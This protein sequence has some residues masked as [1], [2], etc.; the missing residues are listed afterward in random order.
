MPKNQNHLYNALNQW[1]SQPSDWSHLSHLTTCLWLV[2]AVIQ[3]GS[4]NLTKWVTYVP[5]RGIFAQST[6]RRIQRW[7][8]N[9]RINVHRLYQPLIQAALAGWEE[10]TIFLA[11]D[12]SLFWDEY[13]L[14]R[15]CVVYRGRALPVVWR[16]LEHKSA[17]VAFT[18]YQEMLQQAVRRLPLGKRVVLL[19]DRGFVHTELMRMLTV[20]LGW[21]YRIRVK[22]NT[23]IWRVGKGW[24]QLKDL[25]CAR[26]EAVC[27]HNVRLH[28]GAWYGIVHVI[29]GRNNVNGEFWAIV[30]DERTT[31]HTFQE[32][33]LRFDIE[34]N[35]LDDQS[36]GWNIQ[37]SEIRSVVA[38]SRLWF[39]L[40]LATLYVTAQGDA[41]VANGHRRR[42]DT[43]WFRGNS[44]FRIGWEWV[45]AACFKG[46]QL[47]SAVSFH[48]HHDPDRAISSTKQDQSR[49]Y[50]LEFQVRTFVYATD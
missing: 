12:T 32:Y 24:C 48:S 36:N 4:V 10:E 38:L 14:V 41:V 30:S 20:Q 43:H 40:A 18:D 21:S 11:L 47:I 50:R 13:C 29:V 23:W 35:F 7:L 16:V 15:L 45:K 5:C 34:E 49:R 9:P 39:I 1:I 31:L 27:L 44:Y 2:I 6:Q 46:W 3:T 19:A 8:Y 26:G 42:I 28:K 22:S 33:G 25:H 37:R 17:S